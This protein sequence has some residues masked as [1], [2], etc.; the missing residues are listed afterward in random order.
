MEVVIFSYLD[1]NFIVLCDIIFYK[2]T[3]YNYNTAFPKMDGIATA[4]SERKLQLT[5]SVQ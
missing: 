5:L 3:D 2:I 1:A 4:S